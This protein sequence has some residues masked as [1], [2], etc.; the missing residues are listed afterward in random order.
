MNT[1]QIVARFA[2][3]AAA[4]GVKPSMVQA[5]KFAREAG[6]RA[7]T[8]KATLLGYR[9]ADGSA[10]TA[11]CVEFLGTFKGE[12][13]YIASD[14]DAA[15][16]ILA[17]LESTAKRL[18]SEI[19]NA[20]RDEEDELIDPEHVQHLSVTLRQVYVDIARYAPEKASQ[21]PVMDAQLTMA[22]KRAQEL[23]DE[24]Y[25]RKTP[26]LGVYGA[27][28]KSGFDD[29]VMA[30]VC[31]HEY[32]RLLQVYTQNEIVTDPAGFLVVESGK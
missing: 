14:E 21:T 22:A 19:K 2:H 3:T 31:G 28:E 8:S 25:A 23:A 9:F 18:E 32:V 4:D 7:R 5:W 26:F 11:D 1:A 27:M 6:G 30:K 20:R 16:E 29:G 15:R 17:E 10:V 24:T 13:G 12:R